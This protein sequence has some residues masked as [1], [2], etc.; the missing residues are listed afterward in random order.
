MLLP[1]CERS[2]VGHRERSH[3]LAVVFSVA[4]CYPLRL[5]SSGCRPR[6]H[7]RRC[8]LQLH[9]PDMDR[10]STA[11]DAG[12]VSRT[13]DFENWKWVGVA[14]LREAV[15]ESG[16]RSDSWKPVDDHKDGKLIKNRHKSS[17]K[18]YRWG[19][20]TNILHT[21]KVPEGLLLIW[22]HWAIE[23]SWKHIW[24]PLLREFMTMLINRTMQ[25]VKIKKSC[26]RQWRQAEAWV[27]I[28]SLPLLW[29]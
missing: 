25:N 15:T 18:H 29:S 14:S 26:I 17:K 23:N 28:Q 22:Q 24:Y 27:K 2:A 3:L 1:R 6:L 10:I 5:C 8:W 16:I 12:R 9:S 21:S 11:A 4:S 7:S 13:W 20:R 19:C